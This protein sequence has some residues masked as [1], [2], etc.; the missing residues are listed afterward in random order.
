MSK[1]KLLEDL[2]PATKQRGVGKS[3]YCPKCGREAEYYSA[4]YIHCQRCDVAKPKSAVVVDDEK[5][6]PGW[7]DFV[8]NL[9]AWYRCGACYTQTCAEPDEV[10]G[11]L[12]CGCG[13]DLWRLP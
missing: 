5:T 10:A 9:K 4:N 6:D 12:T 2:Q 3:A 1:G 11:G 13:G 7:G 8:I